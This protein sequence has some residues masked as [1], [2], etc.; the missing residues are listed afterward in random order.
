M[1]SGSAGVGA[2]GVASGH[3]RPHSSSEVGDLDNDGY[4]GADEDLG[5]SGPSGADFQQLFDDGSVSP[6]QTQREYSASTLIRSRGNGGSRG[7]P[8][9]SS[10]T[11]R[12]VRAHS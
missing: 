1:V 4:D 3:K 5:E 2:S 7:C 12:H 11:I 9:G 6:G 8:A 10:L